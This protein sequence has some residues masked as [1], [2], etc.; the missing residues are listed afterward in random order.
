MGGERER[1]GGGGEEKRTGLP[2]S[3]SSLPPSAF[4]PSD[5]LH[6]PHNP[7]PRRTVVAKNDV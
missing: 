2:D 4:P 6:A 3:L 7:P 5:R 1:K